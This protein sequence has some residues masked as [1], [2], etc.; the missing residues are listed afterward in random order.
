MNKINTINNENNNK[1]VQLIDDSIKI[2]STDIHSAEDETNI[3][4]ENMKGLLE[5]MKTEGI[6]EDDIVT[7]I[8]KKYYNDD[9]EPIIDYLIDALRGLNQDNLTTSDNTNTDR[10]AEL[11]ENISKLTSELEGIERKELTDI[12][13]GLAERKLENTKEEFV[14][15]CLRYRCEGDFGM[16]YEHYLYEYNPDENKYWITELDINHN[17]IQSETAS[18]SELKDLIVEM[19]AMPDID[20]AKESGE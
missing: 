10:K 11:K 18:I 12:I 2:Y 5:I 16:G 6:T 3:I 7:W 17:P 15:G 9:N 8:M 14:K 19:E 4:T 1:I 13:E 20:K